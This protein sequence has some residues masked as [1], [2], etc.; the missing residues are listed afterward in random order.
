[1]VDDHLAKVPNLAPHRRQIVASLRRLAEEAEQAGAVTCAATVDKEGAVVASLAVFVTAGM[2]EPALNTVAA[3]AAQVASTGQEGPYADS[4]ADWRDV[5]IVDLPAGEAVQIRSH[6]TLGD[7]PSTESVR[8]I[9]METLIPIPGAKHILNVVLTSPQ[10][11]L[12]EELFDLFGLI[13]E[14]L[15][16]EEASALA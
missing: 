9:S 13:T 1:M 7:E 11:S 6:S 10:T 15:A 4:S 3:I 16:W 12:A 14:T 5:R 8:V 2:P